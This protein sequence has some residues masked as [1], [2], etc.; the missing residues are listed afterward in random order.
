MKS[1]IRELFIRAERARKQLLSPILSANGLTPGQGQA[2]IL[3]TLLKED[4]LNQKELSSRC[5]MDTTTMSR[6]IDNLEKLELLKREMNPESRRS[7]IICLTEKGREKALNIR[8]MFNDF[9][10]ILRKDIS[11]EDME[12][13]KGILAKICENLE[14]KVPQENQV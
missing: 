3:Y 12:F 13:F 5:H 14:E 4:R 9:E 6:N 8:E 11:E 10:S 1:N 7:V 2:G